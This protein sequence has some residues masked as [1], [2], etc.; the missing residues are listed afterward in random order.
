[1]EFTGERYFPC[2]ETEGGFTEREHWQRY[3]FAQELFDKNS[4]VLDIAC[5]G[6]YGSDLLAQKLKYVIGIDISEEAVMYSSKKYI[7]DNLH[8]LVGDVSNIPLDD[9]SVDGIVSFETIEHVDEQMQ[10]EFLKESKRI[11]RDDGI[12]V[13]S[14]PNKPIASDFAYKLWGYK[15]IYHK[16][17]YE[18]DAFEQLLKNFYKN[19][20]LL[21][22][23]KET[24][25]VLS[26][27]C[28]ESLEVIWGDRKNNKDTQ[29]IIAVCSDVPIAGNIPNLITLD[30]DYSYLREQKKY[31]DLLKD[32][33]N[34]MKFFSDYKSQLTVLE[35]KIEELLTALKQSQKEIDILKNQNTE[36]NEKLVALKGEI[37]NLNEEKSSLQR[38]LQRKIM[39]VEVAENSES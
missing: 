34:V 6:G 38:E 29:N 1:M 8:F 32:T 9:C 12:F 13:V 23:R 21:Y 19:V 16:K 17:E 27:I 39:Q 10:I 5:G 35:S 15:N 2:K 28:P 18:I 31:S 37:E 25:L 33:G 22:Q 11:L 20:T 4:R 26:S 7:R 14:C 3:Y 24:N 36:K 30:I